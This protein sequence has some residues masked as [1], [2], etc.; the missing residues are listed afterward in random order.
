[1][2][3][4]LTDDCFRSLV[5]SL[6][7]SRLDYGNFLLVAL[8]ACISPVTSGVCSPCSGSF[9]ISTAPL[10]SHHR[11]SCNTALA[12]SAITCRFQ[13]GGHGVSRASRPRS[14]LRE[15]ADSRCRPAGASSTTVI[16][17]TVTSRSDILSVYRRTAPV[18][19]SCF[20]SLQFST[21][22]HSVITFKCFPS[23]ATDIS[24]LQNHSPTFYSLAVHAFVVSVIVHYFSHAKNHD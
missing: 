5:L 4:F 12:A 15:S 1:M 21:I 2:R 20:R 19:C 23:P 11:R 18:S 17:F 6:V 9:D 14:T 16:V 7:H 24:L 8:P 22:G 10:R 3:R 13:G